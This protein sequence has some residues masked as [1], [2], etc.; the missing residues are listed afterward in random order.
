MSKKLQIHPKPFL[1]SKNISKT[2]KATFLVPIVFQL[3]S[4][5]EANAVSPFS[6]WVERPQSNAQGLKLHIEFAPS[7]APQTLESYRKW[8]AQCFMKFEAETR[9]Q[10]T[11]GILDITSLSSGWQAW[12]GVQGQQ[13]EQCLEFLELFLEGALLAAYQFDEHKTQRKNSTYHWAFD[14]QKTQNHFSFLTPA[15]LDELIRKL[16]PVSESIALTRDWSNQPSNIGT[17]IY[18]A[19]EAKRIAKKTGLKVKVLNEIQARKENLNLFLAVGAGSARQSQFVILD[20]NPSKNS[21]TQSKAN[22]KASQ[23]TIAL[24]GKGVTFDSGG[25][26]IKPSARMEEMKHDMTGAATVMGAMNLIAQ[27]KPNTRVVAVLAF[28]ENM[29]DG[30]AVQPG[31][32]IQSRSGKTVEIINTDA[33][34]RLILADALDYVQDHYKPNCIVNVATLTGAVSIA[35]GKHCCGIMGNDASFVQKVIQSGSKHSEVM[36]ELPLFDEYFEDLK[37]EHADMKNSANDGLAGTIRGGIFLK[38][39]IKNNTPWAH[40]DISNMSRNLGHTP[41]Y[42]RIGASGIYVRALAEL[43]SNL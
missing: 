13:E 8:G 11:I 17:P 10:N 43:C 41:Y 23:K 15:K 16:N 20:Y 18:Y 42:P 39:F 27:Q 32:I 1:G 5:S 34:G 24:V 19:S 2:E 36:W 38:Q 3:K 28:V 31:N 6:L 14:L 4:K 40:L 26:S 12:T 9:N 30:L 35:L 22:R 7:S 29:P 25:I 33:E 37:T 21:K